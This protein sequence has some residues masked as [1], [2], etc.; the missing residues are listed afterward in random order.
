MVFFGIKPV[1]FGNV[2]KNCEVYKIQLREKA[3]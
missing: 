2:A 1:V 3:S